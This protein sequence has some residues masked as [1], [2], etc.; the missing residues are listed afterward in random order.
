MATSPFH[1]EG[2][3]MSTYL[4]VTYLTSLEGDRDA[5][6]PILSKEVW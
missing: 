3:G 4:Y 1:L 5:H 2:M 6:L